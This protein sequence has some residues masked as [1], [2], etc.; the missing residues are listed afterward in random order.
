MYLLCRSRVI[1]IA[2]A[3]VSLLA[4]SACGK[5]KSNSSASLT[6]KVA[7]TGSTSMT[8]L[9]D[10]V[11]DLTATALGNKSFT[12]DSFKMWIDTIVLQNSDGTSN[13]FYTCE[14]SA[15]DCEVDFADAASIKKLQDK[16]NAVSIAT[17][18]YTKVWL[19]CN[20]NGAGYVKFKGHATVNGVTKY[21]VDPASN[22]GNPVTTDSAKNSE[23][24][25]SN[26]GCGLT[27]PLSKTLTVADKDTVLIT[28]FSDLTNSVY[29]AANQSGGMGGCKIPTGASSGDGFCM[30][31]PSVF[32]FFG[33]T[34][35][36]V[37]NYLVAHRSDASVLSQAIA[38]T[39]IKI[40]KD[41]TGTPF[42]ASFNMYYTET[43]PDANQDGAASYANSVTSFSVNAD[44]TLTMKS[45][46]YG[47]TAFKRADHTGDVVSGTIVNGAGSSTL[48]TYHYHAYAYTP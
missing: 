14:T 13:Q 45:Q 47:F 36:T 26:V 7:K 31:Y 46:D 37:E 39:H 11:Q 8:S 42:W 15:A 23:I 3:T 43:T 38:N 1:N 12:P 27:M 18:T 30:N 32:P 21:T 20:P 40:I 48:S 28:M 10:S 44:S 34:T 16:L 33:E 29:F 35:P 41:S 5:K 4:I 17:G 25:L 6:L 9:S 24:N 19:S 22:S 2:I